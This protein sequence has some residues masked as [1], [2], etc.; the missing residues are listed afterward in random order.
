LLA[1]KGQLRNFYETPRRS[2]WEFLATLACFWQWLI[3]T[4][5]LSSPLRKPLNIGHGDVIVA[6]QTPWKAFGAFAYIILTGGAGGVGQDRP[7]PPAAVGMDGWKVRSARRGS[8]SALYPLFR[9]SV[10]R[11]GAGV[12]RAVL[13]N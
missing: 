1:F 9:R 4:V 8:L 10:R 3:A 12:D 5:T 6:M 13:N 7:P 2:T 11:A